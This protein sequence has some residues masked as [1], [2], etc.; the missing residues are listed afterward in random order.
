M[1]PA[2]SYPS[3]FLS[4][5]LTNSPVD[6]SIVAGLASTSNGP[7][8]TI[9]IAVTS[10]VTSLGTRHEYEQVPPQ[11]YSNWPVVI[12]LPFESRISTFGGCARPR[13]GP[14]PAAE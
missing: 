6:I 13:S 9:G 14:I 2:E 7:T 11:P 4:D 12:T 10:P 1:Y 8:L 5:G 3:S